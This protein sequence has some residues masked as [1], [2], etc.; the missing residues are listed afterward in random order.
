M[1][2]KLNIEA[3]IES[4][5]LDSL[6]IILK[7]APPKEYANI[8]RLFHDAM[9]ELNL[10]KALDFNKNFYSKM[11]ILW[12]KDESAKIKNTQHLSNDAK[13]HMINVINTVSKH[14]RVELY[15]LFDPAT[16]KLIKYSWSM[17]GL[18]TLLR[19]NAKNGTRLLLSS[20][21]FY[22]NLR[23]QHRKQQK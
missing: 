2:N 23:N 18:T 20:Y 19:K 10:L 12:E 17:K 13:T 14:R 15:A 21:Q 9:Y 6:N 4:R 16:M 11:L 8:Q 7:S 1:K 3:A 22:K 5:A